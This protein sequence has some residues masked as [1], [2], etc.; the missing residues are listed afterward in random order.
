MRSKT[1]RLAGIGFVAAMVA[2]FAS[3]GMGVAPQE[4]KSAPSEKKASSVYVCA[5]MKTSSCPCASM[6]NKQGKCP[7]GDEMK[8]EPREGKWAEANRKSLSGEGK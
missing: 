4:A 8:A 6:S 5:C 2:M 7:C 1:S 3:L